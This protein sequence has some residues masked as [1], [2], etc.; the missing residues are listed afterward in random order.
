MEKTYVTIKGKK[1]EFMSLSKYKD[2]KS[3]SDY[4]FWSDCLLTIKQ[5]LKENK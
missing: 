3:P 5:K 4:A 2:G 1:K